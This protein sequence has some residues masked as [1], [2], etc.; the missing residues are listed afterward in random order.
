M[1][2]GVYNI[3]IEDYHNGS[4]ISRSGLMHFDKSPLH[5]WH[6]NINPLREPV[7]QDEIVTKSG[8][9]GFGNA[10]H[11]MVLE[12]E[13]FDKRYMLAEKFDRRTK[14]GKEEYAA[15]LDMRGDRQFIAQDAMQELLNMKN[16]ID[17]N[18]W[19]KDL[20]AGADY[21]KSI[22]WE[23]STSSLLCKVRPDAWHDEFI[24]D[25]K[26]SM[27]A[28]L[29]SFQRSFY[30]YGYHV[31]AGM[32]N[33]AILHVTG[34]DVRN[35]VFIAIEK[36]PPYAVGVY[37]LSE[38]GLER[39]IQKFKDMILGVKICIEKDEWP[40]YTPGSIELPNWV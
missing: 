5:Y 36:E 30:A 14:A 32:I 39:G 16:S 12:P 26:T 20:I 29:K 40:S 9:L 6:N 10:L 31:Q 25:L 24:V 33:Q 3:S 21:E 38:E 22:Y 2:P 1:N 35:F 23:D 37:Q 11:T 8:A 17:L 34:K 19:A 18:P 13:E 27:A 28:D 4:G 15:M 7:R